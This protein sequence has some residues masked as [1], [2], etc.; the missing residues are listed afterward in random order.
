[1][2]C[3]SVRA[4]A[5]L[6]QGFGSSHF[7]KV[8]HC[9]SVWVSWVFFVL[10]SFASQESCGFMPRKGWS[11]MPTPAG[12]FE[13]I[14]GPRPPSVQWPPS[15]GKGKTED[16]SVQAVGR[17]AV[18]LPPPQSSSKIPSLE[19]ALAALGPEESTAKTEITVTLQ[20]ARE[21]DTPQVRFDPERPELQR[22]G[23]EWPGWSRPFQIWET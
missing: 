10:F 2:L 4:V 21:Q 17:G 13:V 18:I 7:A 3:S 12:W 14:R 15:K 19:A 22:D 5:M 6:A 20:R 1:M 9:F 11:V 23:P 16:P 8:P